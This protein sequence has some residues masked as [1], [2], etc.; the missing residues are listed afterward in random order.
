MG[1]QIVFQDQRGV[2]GV[3]GVVFGEDGGRNRS[4]RRGRKGVLP[5]FHAR[6]D[7]EMLARIFLRQDAG[8][9]LMNPFVSASVI[10]V[11]VRVDGLLDWNPH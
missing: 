2:I 5:T 3:Q 11:P 6:I 10:E 8:T 1:R 4:R 7:Q 9:G